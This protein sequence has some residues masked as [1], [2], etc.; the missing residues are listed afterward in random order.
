M[1]CFSFECSGKWCDEVY[2]VVLDL[3]YFL[4][5]T[6]WRHVGSYIPTT[7]PFCTSSFLAFS[8][9]HVGWFKFTHGCQ[10]IKSP[11]SR[12]DGAQV[13]DQVSWPRTLIRWVYLMPDA[14][15]MERPLCVLGPSVVGDYQ[16]LDSVR[17]EAGWGFLALLCHPLLR[18]H[19]TK[20]LS[21]CGIK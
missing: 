6:H 17:G 10:Q 4:K 13:F 19:P 14:L 20:P 21:V 2:I 3:A 15:H 18:L 11:W 8:Q 1:A 16:A 5:H 9:W 7:A 12:V